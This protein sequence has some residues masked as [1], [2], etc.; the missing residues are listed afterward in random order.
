MQ[1]IPVTA[2]ISEEGSTRTKATEFKLTENQTNHT[3]LTTTIAANKAS[4]E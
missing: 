4:K 1:L 3:A 2:S